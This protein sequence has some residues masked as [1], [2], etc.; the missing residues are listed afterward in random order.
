MHLR[1]ITYVAILIATN[2][3]AQSS[4]N[5]PK[6]ITILTDANLIKPALALTR[7]YSKQT[8]APLTSAVMSANVQEQISQGLEAHVVLT[9]N[10]TIVEEMTARGLTDVTATERFAKT[11]LALVTTKTSEI[12][13]LFSQHISVAAIIYGTPNLPVFLEPAQSDAGSKSELLFEGY[14]FS[15]SLQKRA[16]IKNSHAEILAALRKNN[17]LALMLA[18]DATTEP[19]LVVLNTLP[20]SLSSPVPIYALVLASEAM[21][22]SRSF[23]NFLDSPQAKQ[24]L[25]KSGFEP[26]PR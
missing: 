19:D 8:H 3:G 12:N 23:V 13:M 14:E 25:I 17:G 6:N 9:S 26:G 20:D 11:R 15:P 22:S 16:E 1:H 10:K 2:A 4:P 5:Q 21:D 18:S 24:V 7:A